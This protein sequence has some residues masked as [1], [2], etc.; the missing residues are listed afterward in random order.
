MQTPESKIKKKVRGR[1]RAAGAYVF[2]PVQMGMGMPTLDD[3]VCFSGKFVA[4]EY[5]AAGGKPTPRQ[6]MTMK[7]IRQ[8]GGIVIW[9]DSY[10]GIIEELNKALGLEL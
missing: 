6:Q 7:V 2:S 4:I 9:A 10:E 8:A 5:K 3:L 1:L